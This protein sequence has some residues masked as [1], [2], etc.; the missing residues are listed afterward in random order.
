MSAPAV[1]PATTVLL[2][3]DG[4]DGVEVFLV[5]RHARSRFMPDAWVFPGGRVDDADHEL[6]DTQVSGG[7]SVGE[8]LGLPPDAVRGFLVAGVRETFEEAGIWLGTGELPTA[9]RE[10]LN[11]GE[12]RFTDLLA[13]H[14]AHID[15]DGLAPWS[16]WVTPASEPRRY[17]T[18]FVVAIT[19]ADGVHDDGETVDSGWFTPSAALAA[20]A[21]GEVRMAPPT[22]W[23]VTELAALGTVKAVLDSASQ[24]A[25]ARIEPILSG[26]KGAV[27]LTLPGHAG[28]P[29]P[30]I[31]GLPTSIAFEQGRWWAR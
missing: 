14:D 20:V 27:S 30:A 22:W 23:T 12:V 10:P 17:D 8:R 24:R 11:N 31:D 18:R 28:H 6:P 19:D 25:I 5:K 15:L 2:L 13:A 16:W 9:L 3:R 4:D 1:K 21:S 26:T 29:D 7:E